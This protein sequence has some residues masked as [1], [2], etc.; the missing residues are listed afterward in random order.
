MDKLQIGQQKQRLVSLDVFRGITIAGMIL[1]NNPGNWSKIYSPLGHAQWDGWTP[2]DLV[3]PFFLFIV[4]VALTF[5]FSKKLE[6]K[7]NR[8]PL[9][10]QVVRRTIIIFLLGMVMAGFP[11]Y[12]LIGPYVL[13]IL[14]LSLAL[15]EKPFAGSLQKPLGALVLIGSIAYFIMDYQYFHGSNIRIPGVLQRI[16]VCYLATSL[17]VM[18]AGTVG[19]AVWV[20]VLA[21]GYWI[22]TEYVQP[23]ADFTAKV[24]SPEGMLHEWI[25][26]MCLGDHLYSWRPD[27]EGI[28]STLPAI[29]TCLLGV[30][31]GSWL[32]SSR[33]GTEKV[34]G[35]FF[36]ANIALVLG[37]ALNPVIPI[38]KKIWTTSYVVFTAGMALHFL[39]M[40]YWLIDVKQWKKWATPFVIFGTNAIVVYV[41]SG[42]LARMLYR[43][44]VGAVADNSISV[45][46]WIYE[47]LFHSW[48]S[49]YNSSL[50]YA[51][52]YVFFWLLVLIPLYRRRIF[53]KV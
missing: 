14:G 26:V 16:A 47:N 42:L 28:L 21:G 37:L 33:D 8:G 34:A 38:N 41:A 36:A 29:A 49:D 23:P 22:I 30:L 27:P 32:R 4:G 46:T 31:A 20:V 25:D 45:K 53:I 1:V 43:W 6:Q 9:L 17:I 5:S 10:A 50:F 11:D 18:T 12:R 2:T 52:A 48:L 19:R 35:M 7:H 15:M 13:V 40:C 44:K 24:A 3:F 51:L 39:A